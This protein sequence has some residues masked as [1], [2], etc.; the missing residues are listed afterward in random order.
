MSSKKMTK[1]LQQKWLRT[2]V[3]ELMSSEESDDEDNM[4]IHPLPWRSKYVTAMFHQIDQY[5]IHYKSAQ[6]R[7]QMKSRVTGSDSNRSCPQEGIPQWALSTN[8]V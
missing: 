4:I 7:R 3:N 1:D 6:A 5:N 8:H 2:M